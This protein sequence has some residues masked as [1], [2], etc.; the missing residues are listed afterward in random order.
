MR[1]RCSSNKPSMSNHYENWV[2]PVD[3]ED[4]VRKLQDEIRELKDAL[5]QERTKVEDLTDVQSKYIQLKE[6][7]AEMA[8]ELWCVKREKDSLSAL[9]LSDLKEI[10]EKNQEIENGKALR[11]ELNSQISNQSDEIKIL[12]PLANVGVAIRLRCLEQTRVKI[13]HIHTG[14]AIEPKADI[15]I[16]GNQAAHEGRYE[17]DIALLT[18][19]AWED[20]PPLLSRQLKGAIVGLYP[21]KERE[22][23]DQRRFS[24]ISQM[25]NCIGTLRIILFTKDVN[26]PKEK[27]EVDVINDGVKKIKIILEGW[28][29]IDHSGANADSLATGW[30][31]I[32]PC[33]KMV[34]GLQSVRRS[35]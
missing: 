2:S 22:C 18:H 15:I 23:Y 10:N 4:D 34:K 17:A 11:D 5:S 27:K 16:A 13:Q 30:A 6:Q 20:L 3:R 14:R 29:K 31:E 25:L 9:A 26:K 19:K 12:T 33:E 8:V 1:S 28:Q 32:H 24:H 21:E 7:H 35:S